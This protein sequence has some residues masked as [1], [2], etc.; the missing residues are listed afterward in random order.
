MTLI[1]N[2][3]TV[4]DYSISETLGAFVSLC[5]TYS[6]GCLKGFPGIYHMTNYAWVYGQFKLNYS[7]LIEPYKLGKISSEEFI[8]NLAKI[9]Y[10]MDNLTEENRNALLIDAWNKSIKITEHT[11]SRF[12]FLAEKAQAEP[13]YIISNTNE[14]D[15]IAIL[16]LI[17][18]YNPLLK[19]KDPINISIEAS[20]QPVEIAP[21]MFLCLS[22]RYG[23]FKESTLNTASLLKEVTKDMSKETVTLVSQHQG[24][25][26]TGQA[27][28]LKDCQTAE[29]FFE[30]KL[31]L[32]LKKGQ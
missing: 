9:F 12:S 8:G 4:H 21:N 2:L 13:V 31:S 26:R 30:M 16:A 5:D 25:L 28:G 20:N 3:S 11:E 17:K 18:K 19:F 14:L 1:V 23:A 15:A 27:L 32:S 7:T 10:F 22:Y 6:N 24:D 29:E